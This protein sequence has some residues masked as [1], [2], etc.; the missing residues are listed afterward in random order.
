MILIVSWVNGPKNEASLVRK[1]NPVRLT[2]AVL[3][4]IQ[5]FML[6]CTINCKGLNTELKQRCLLEVLEDKKVD[7]ALLQ[8]TKIKDHEIFDSF[9]QFFKGQLFYALS[10]DNSAG[11]AIL[12]LPHCLKFVNVL[13]SSSDTNG[14]W[15]NVTVDI[16]DF[17]LT[18]MCVY[19]P[20]SHGS[21]HTFF[22]DISAIIQDN[23]S[24]NL[25]LGGDF[26]CVL[27][28]NIDR[29]SQSVYNDTSHV[30]LKHVCDREHLFDSYRLT[31]PHDRQFTWFSSDGR[32]ASRLDRIYLQQS[33]KGNLSQT[34]VF[35]VAFSDHNMVCVTLDNASWIKQGSGFWKFNN[36]LLYDTNYHHCVQSFWQYWLRMKDSYENLALW[37]EEGKSG[38]AH[39]SKRFA[40]KKARG[41]RKRRKALDKFLFRISCKVNNGDQSY[42]DL[43]VKIKHDINELD[44]YMLEGA[45]VRSRA[46]MHA[47]GEK[48][49]KYFCNLE[50]ARGIEKITRH[51]KT[52]DG[53]VA[54]S[55]EEILDAV[56]HFYESL[57]A[58]EGSDDV[59]S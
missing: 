8:E 31:N 47:E 51:L 23:I 2:M 18:I 49:T 25:I 7:I 41:R 21:R 33:L 37:W 57:Y 52:K 36:S 39:I 55:N 48:P 13:A 14:S 30:E 3:Y 4:T 40:L 20:V 34:S 43:L 59:A 11:V 44:Q 46:Q 1:I 24:E 5:L 28:S 38:L 27:D 16:F 15:V 42:N 17:S 10:C 35:P 12:I 32:I 58:S 54:N 19:A 6:I 50:K 22:H 26:N 56:Y 53:L 29:K 45:K 9:K